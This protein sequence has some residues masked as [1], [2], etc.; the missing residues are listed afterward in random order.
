MHDAVYLLAVGEEL[1]ED[2]QAG[3]DSVNALNLDYLRLLFR[4]D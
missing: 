2:G 3:E 4:D 1:F